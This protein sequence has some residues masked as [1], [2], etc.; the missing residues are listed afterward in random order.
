MAAPKQN[1][2]IRTNQRR[3]VGSIS[4]ELPKRLLATERV[5]RA[6]NESLVVSQTQAG[7]VARCSIGSERSPRPGGSSVTTPKVVCWGIVGVRAARLLALNGR[8]A[9]ARSRR[10][11]SRA[12]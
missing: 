11:R 4:K 6:I 3:V 5:R 10:P 2:A 9:P 1:E 8:F 7:R 12:Q